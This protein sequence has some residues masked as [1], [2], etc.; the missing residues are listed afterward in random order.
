MNKTIVITENFV[1]KL[2]A[3]GVDKYI[4]DY[5]NKLID[6][7]K[8]NEAGIIFTSR[9]SGGIWDNWRVFMPYCKVVF[10]ENKRI[11]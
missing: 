5:K 2:G 3:E 10:F 8:W 6:F 9:D 4:E 1:E 11:L 7:F